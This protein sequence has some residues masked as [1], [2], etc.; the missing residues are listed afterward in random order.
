M[1]RT[2]HYVAY[3]STIKVYN[4]N[5]CTYGRDTATARSPGESAESTYSFNKGTHIPNEGAMQRF[6]TVPTKN[7]KCEV[8]ESPSLPT[9][10]LP[11][12]RD[13]LRRH[14]KLCLLD[15]DVERRRMVV[16]DPYR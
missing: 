12:E 7:N 14:T 4:R 10:D 1:E 16:D 15:A 6:P 11:R 8:T 13:G 2:K 5:I 3:K 9:G